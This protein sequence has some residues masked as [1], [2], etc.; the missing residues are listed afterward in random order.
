MIE[1]LKAMTRA[2]TATAGRGGVQLATGVRNQL[3]SGIA[4]ATTNAAT[5]ELDYAANWGSY[6]SGIS[7]VPSPEALLRSYYAGTLTTERLQSGLAYHGVIWRA[8]NGAAGGRS[9]YWDSVIQ[10]GQPMFSLEFLRKV[11]LQDATRIPLLQR[12]MQLEG[13]FTPSNIDLYLNERENLD[14]SSL[15]ALW[16]NGRITTDD[17]NREARKLG[18]FPDQLDW[19]R[20]SRYDRPG[21]SMALLMGRLGIIDKDTMALYVRSDGF[22]EN[23]VASQVMRLQNVLPSASDVIGSFGRLSNDATLAGRWGLDLDKPGDYTT[24]MQRLGLEYSAGS[25]PF[26][27]PDKAASTWGQLFWRD[28]WRLFDLGTLRSIIQRFRGDAADPATWS[29]PDVQPLTSSEVNSLLAA[30]GIPPNARPYVLALTYQPIGIRHL[31]MIMRYNRQPRDWLI[32]R[33]QDNGF[34]PDDATKQADALIANINE[35][36]AAPILAAQRAAR[37][38]FLSSVIIGYK[39]GAIDGPGLRATVIAQGYGN[40]TADLVLQTANIELN[41]G[42]IRAVSARAKSDLYSGRTNLA[43]VTQRLLSTGADPQ[44]VQLTVNGW[45]AAFGEGRRHIA[46]DKVLKLLRKGYISGGEALQRLNYLGWAQ[47][48]ELLLLAE[49]QDQINQD[50]ADA[51]DAAD[52]ATAK[53]VAALNRML[54][55]NAA[56]ASKLQGMLRKKTPPASI[57]K[58]VK[59]GLWT[60]AQATARLQLMGYDAA[61]IAVMLKEAAVEQIG[62]PSTVKARQSQANALLRRLYPPSRTVSFY[63]DGIWTRAEAESKLLAVGVPADEAAALLA[64]A[65]EAIKDKAGS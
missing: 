20:Q 59:R 31:R 43:G 11:S 8:D 2:M 30:N 58:W 33:Y 27:V 21:S 54:K 4:Q 29:N 38:R 63:R 34:R 49:V 25:G 15:F 3:I 41:T 10:A 23:D 60:T 1:A 5:R 13:L 62:G 26:G 65:D 6:G 46:T 53:Q 56:N 61:T 7:S 22:V 48:D 35:Q 47:A 40:E 55:Q 9:Q 44:W 18:F 19:Y 28:H 32:A 37:R 50:A 12:A 45:Q 16:L 36:E 57:M 24:W 51:A 39:G 64:Q 14:L 42:I 17:F 52:L